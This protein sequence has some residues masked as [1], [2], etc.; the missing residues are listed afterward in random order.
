MTAP[1]KEWRH[2]QIAALLALAAHVA[3]AGLVL[4][5]T[6]SATPNEPEPVVLVE[7]PPLGAAAPAL[8]SAPRPAPQPIRSQARPPIAMPPVAAPPRPDPAI[9]PPPAPTRSDVAEAPASA[10][11]PAPE[12]AAQAAS[13]APVATS[14][15]ATGPGTSPLPG[16]DPRARQQEADY[17][18]L[19]SAHLNRRKV[20]PT[21]ARRARQQ[22]VVTVRFTVNRQG[23]VSNV[24]IRRSS[25][26]ALL[27]S[28]TLD[29]LQR[30][31]P[32]PPMPSSMQRDS[33]TLSLPI[34]YS[35]RTN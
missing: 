9:L 13:A 6:R 17:F 18:A 11:S 1:S 26:H 4:S 3:V 12:T 14:A 35:L 22:G 28:A 34:D 32:L 15:A 33:I 24:S 25:G 27:D 30:V 2:W 19:V 23:H 16:T 21:E 31:A 20:Y 7:L 29:L 10:P 8:A 5:W